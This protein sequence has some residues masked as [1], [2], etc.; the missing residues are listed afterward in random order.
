MIRAAVEIAGLSWAT[1]NAIEVPV[2]VNAS[3]TSNGTIL[4]ERIFS[5]LYEPI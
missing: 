4:R 2:A 3:M 1:R 5:I